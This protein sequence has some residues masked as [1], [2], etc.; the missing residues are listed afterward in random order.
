MTHWLFFSFITLMLF[1][2]WGLFAKLA[3]RDLGAR[4]ALVW[5]VIGTLLVGAGVA[6]VIKFRPEVHSRGTVFGLL[7]GITGTLGVLFFLL[8]MVKGKA[9][10]VVPLTALYPVVTLVLVFVFLREPLTAKQGVGIA[11]AL[12][13]MVL[14][15][16]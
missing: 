1:G 13:A 9:S 16:L 11:L 4:S 7:T 5:Q 3:A 14:F 10:V 6:A 12:A 8:A 2:F 15:S